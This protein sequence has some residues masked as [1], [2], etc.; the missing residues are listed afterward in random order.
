MLLMLVFCEKCKGCCDNFS[1]VGRGVSQIVSS[2]DV[3]FDVFYKRFLLNLLM[4]YYECYDNGLIGVKCN[5][6]CDKVMDQDV[7]G[8][9]VNNQSGEQCQCYQQWFCFCFF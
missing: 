6:L 7:N 1:C 4:V 2:V 8:V 9:I 3:C 5:N